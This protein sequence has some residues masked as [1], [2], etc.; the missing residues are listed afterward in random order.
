MSVKLQLVVILLVALTS[1]LA[2][3]A[4][5]PVDWF[6]LVEDD[7]ERFLYKLA[8]YLNDYDD[9]EPTKGS[10]RDEP[11]EKKEMCMLPMRRG[12]CRA[13]ITRWR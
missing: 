6:D 1:I 3:P 4:P 9:D 12:L 11:K 8:D 10:A 5:A 7:G 2:S 13:L